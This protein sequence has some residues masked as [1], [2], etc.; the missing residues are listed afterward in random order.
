MKLESSDT[1]ICSAHFEGVKKEYFWQLPS[2]FPWSKPCKEKK[3]PARRGLDFNDVLSETHL[4]SSAEFKFEAVEVG[5]VKDITETV[6]SGTPSL[7]SNKVLSTEFHCTASKETQ[8]DTHGGKCKE[9]K[10]MEEQI[11]ILQEKIS[12]LTIEVHKREF[13]IKRF[14]NDIMSEHLF[15]YW[16]S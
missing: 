4:T 15:L 5:A 9:H 11:K 12:A 7:E 10:E 14:Q 6:E 2:I 13:C 1:R 3:L 8:A 16:I